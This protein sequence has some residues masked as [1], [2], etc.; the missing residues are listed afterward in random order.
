[1]PPSSLAF[2]FDLQQARPVGHRTHGVRPVHGQI[3]DDL[4]QLDTIARH[5]WKVR[6][7]R[8]LNHHRTAPQRAP[9]QGGDI[10]DRLIDVERGVIRLAMFEQIPNAHKH[11]A[12]VTARLDDTLESRFRLLEIGWGLGQPS[13]RPVSV[14]DDRSER[15]ADFVGDRRREF[16]HGRQ[17][18]HLREF[19]LGRLH[20]LVGADAFVLGID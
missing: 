13:E 5:T 7:K 1:M 16:A 4:L 3:H 18:R 8:G 14:R 20:G 15:L 2:D 12:G 9:G 6:G 10:P 17:P 19:R 11:L